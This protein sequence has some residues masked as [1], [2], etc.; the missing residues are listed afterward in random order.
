MAAKPVQSAKE[1]ELL[2]QK[3]RDELRKPENKL[4]ADCDGRVRCRRPPQRASPCGT[5]I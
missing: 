1:A 2:T 3:L 5:E 4:C